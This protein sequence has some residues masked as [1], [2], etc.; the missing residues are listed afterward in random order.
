[1]HHGAS[2]AILKE[3]AFQW[4]GDVVMGSSP[5]FPLPS[6]L[7][8]DAVEQNHDLLVVSLS[9]I[10][11]VVPCP[12]C[13]TPG[14][15]IHSRYRRTVADVACGGQRV[16]LKLTVRKWVCGSPSCSQRIFA[17]RF[18]EL[19]Q[20]YARMTDRLIQTLQSVGTT[21]NGADGARL[22]SKLAMPTTGKTIIRRVLELPLPKDPSIR[23]AGIDE[24]AWKK[25]ARYGTIL[26]DLQRRRVAALLPERSVET[27]TAW[28]VAH[29]QVDIVSRDRGKTFREAASAGAP[30]AKHVVDRFHLQKNFAEALEKFFRHH[31]HSL[32]AVARQLAGK[33]HP[34][35]KSAAERQI[36]QEREQRHQQRVRRHQQIWTLFR[37]GYHKEDIASMVGIG[38]RSVY[39][40]LEHEHPPARETRRRTGHV[41][42]P[43][44]SYLSD[45]WN[46]G[47][48]TAAQL[49]EEVVAQGY[50]GSLR[51]IDRIVRQFR[52][53]RTQPVSRQTITQRNVPST[54][55]AALMMVRPAQHRTKEQLAF[56]DQIVSRDP[57]IA[58]AF[59][60]TQEFGQLLR[61]RQG[62]QRLEQWKA[63]VRVSGITELVRFVEGLADDE[64]AVANACTES[65]SNGM[66]EGFNTK[67]KLI[68]RNSYGQA[69]FPLLQRRVLLHPAAGEAF[70]KEQ[71]RRSSQR[72]ASAEHA[73]ASIS[74][75]C[76]TALA[77]ASMV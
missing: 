38:S 32:K 71:R 13:G 72:S 74:G 12:R 1:M 39:R 34:A 52:L 63:A 7:S 42:G 9:A 43:Y 53:Q 67:V 27:S 15:R 58:T 18:V 69:G 40:A 28:F 57:T 48:H 55:S 62:V 70:D 8:I 23:V 76:P 77:E 26:V 41:A 24:W 37:A 64:G 19:V 59:T 21:T 20:R 75:S 45:R 66:V 60:L 73:D 68:K 17:E 10:S 4:F 31:K 29:P 6:T 22:S 54:K 44:L 2:C 36:E 61:Q 14:S 5:F 46:Q 16:V 11:S 35:P 3:N 50:P 51:T 49:Y 33:A 30:Q 56:I 65:Y 25:G 47:C